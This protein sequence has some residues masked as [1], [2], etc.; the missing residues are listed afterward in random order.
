[1]AS[2]LTSLKQRY[3]Q[4]LARHQNKPLLTGVMAASALVATADGVV[5]FAE[6]MRLDQIIENLETLKVFDVHEGVDLFNEFQDAIFE[7]PKTGHAKAVDAIRKAAGDDEETKQLLIRI[8]LA[9]HE[10][11]GA[12]SL[13]E[14]IEIVTLCSLL[15]MDPAT[16]GLY[17]DGVLSAD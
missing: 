11:D 16:V 17:H 1:M 3:Q 13:A 5:S 15:G 4:E 7:D 9:I 14:Q 2:L 10:A 8:C 6:R 12:V